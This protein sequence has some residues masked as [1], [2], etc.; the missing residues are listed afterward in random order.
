MRCAAIVVAVACATG[1]TVASAQE[2]DAPPVATEAEVDAGP[3]DASAFVLKDLVGLLN[4]DVVVERTDGSIVA[5]LLESASAARIM[6]RL[7]DGR[8]L[9][10]A[11]HEVVSVTAQ[12]A[13]VQAPPIPAKMAPAR[14]RRIIDDDD[15][16]T[17]ARRSADA[18]DWRRAKAESEAAALE[19]EAMRLGNDAGLFMFGGGG[20][21]LV[22]GIA[23][24]IALFVPLPLGL[25]CVGASCLTMIGGGGLALMGVFKNNDASARRMEAARVR[26]A[27]AY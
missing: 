27:M 21:A 11:A 5:G 13:T 24:T 26:G 1:T 3:A 10:V 22:S 9:G 14:A 6:I 20:V 12:P 23:F 25:C 16:P 17:R 15:T 8:V 7:R 4:T 19:G 2:V 18:E